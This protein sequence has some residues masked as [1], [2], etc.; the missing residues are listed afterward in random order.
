[1]PAFSYNDTDEEDAVIDRVQYYADLVTKNEQTIGIDEGNVYRNLVAAMT[2]VFNSAP[3]AALDRE[4]KDATDQDATNEHSRTEIVIP[5]G[6]MRLLE[7]RLDGWGRE[8]YDWY[9]PTSEVVSLQYDEYTRHGPD[10][11]VVAKVP[12]PGAPSGHAFRCWPQSKA[13]STDR[14]AYLGETRPENISSPLQEPVAM[15]AASYTLSAGK[16]E[17]AGLTREAAIVYLNALADGR[18]MAGP[19]ALQEAQEDS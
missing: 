14:F 3:E 9:A 6:F 5:D 19:E 4:S 2:Q 7:L 13:E 8:V 11:P 16:Y 1:M 18:R 12:A 10:D 15:W 17:G